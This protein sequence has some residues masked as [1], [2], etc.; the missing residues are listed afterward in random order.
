MLLN[1]KFRNGLRTVAI[2]LT[3]SVFNGVAS[4]AGG[5]EVTFFGSTS[6]TSVQTN[7]PTPAGF[8]YYDSRGVNALTYDPATKSYNFQQSASAAGQ[9][10]P[11]SLPIVSSSTAQFLNSIYS[12]AG[13]VK[14]FSSTGATVKIDR[15]FP[16]ASNRASAFTTTAL[17]TRDYL[18]ILSTDPNVSSGQIKI[19]FAASVSSGFDCDGRATCTKSESIWSL[20]NQLALFRGSPLDTSTGNI[21]SISNWRAGGISGTNWTNP[22]AINSYCANLSFQYCLSNGRV[23]QSYIFDVRPGNSIRLSSAF[24]M[25]SETNLLI[26]QIGSTPPPLASMGSFIDFGNSGYTLIESL[27]PGIGYVAESGGIYLTSLPGVPEPSSWAM[28]IAGFGLVGGSLRGRRT[29]QTEA[30]KESSNSSR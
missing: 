3:L 25:Q 26:T 29:T 20:S 12:T 6:Y 18:S 7:Q 4:K 9:F 24:S 22:S 14:G 2:V 19:T 17:S 8:S 1:L 16:S 13:V 15:G 11:T 10:T 21:L 27:T 23:S 28:L 30:P 5:L